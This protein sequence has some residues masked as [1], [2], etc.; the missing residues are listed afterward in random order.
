MG[1]DPHAHTDVSRGAALIAVDCVFHRIDL[2]LRNFVCISACTPLQL[3][4]TRSC[5]GALGGPV[6]HGV[7]VGSIDMAALLADCYNG[8]MHASEGAVPVGCTPPTV[9][10][11]VFS[12]GIATQ[13][14][15]QIV[16]IGVLSST[17]QGRLDLCQ[18]TRR[19]LINEIACYDGIQL[20]ARDAC[21][22]DPRFAATLESQIHVRRGAILISFGSQ[23]LGAIVLSERLYLLVPHANHQ[24][25][26]TIQGCYRRLVAQ[27]TRG[28][29][30]TRNA[31]GCAPTSLDPGRQSGDYPCTSAASPAA[32]AATVLESIAVEAGTVDPS[33]ARPPCSAYST[34]AP[35][36]FALIAIEALLMGA[37][38]DL[39]R[40]T[41]DLAA[42]VRTELEELTA[43]GGIQLTVG[44]E[45]LGIIREL[46]LRVDTLQDQ[47]RSLDA[48][49]SQTLEDEAA[50]RGIRLTVVGARDGVGSV[51]SADI[52]ATAN[53]PGME[54]LSA[55]SSS[56][57]APF[58]VPPG[59]APPRAP[60]QMA[61]V[62]IDAAEQL[63]ETYLGHVRTAS[64][65]LERAAFNIAGQE[66]TALLM[67]DQVRNRL[68]K[69]DVAA[70]SVSA[71]AGL[72]ACIASVFGMNTPA[73]ILANVPADPSAP[74]K[75][76]DTWLFLT[77]T[78]CIAIMIAGF[79][80][81]VLTFLYAPRCRPT[82]P[83]ANSLT[84]QRQ[85]RLHKRSSVGD[86]APEAHEKPR[87]S[88]FRS[89]PWPSFS[90]LP[91][92]GEP[93]NH[94]RCLRRATDIQSAS[95]RQLLS[96]EWPIGGGS[97][98]A[99]YGSAR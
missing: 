37:C 86:A 90:L 50:I 31:R 65:S 95:S 76:Y 41:S 16:H 11:P 36:P 79:I 12:V 64:A 30:A 68:L 94:P 63:L 13:D 22:V 75:R 73:P 57:R 43:H 92:P 97:A 72:G 40:H 19:Q 91:S 89:T 7:P 52:P 98:N 17:D 21:K 96:E 55:A 10:D 83:V 85:R 54:P 2:C 84:T 61:P 45:W 35:F 6:L 80:V 53:V 44:T 3:T 5:A 23:R 26:L 93:S 34:P 25:L 69:V 70:S 99:R 14:S 62:A 67:L 1:V 51:A 60:R 39:H 49:L 59:N 20:T 9:E 88:S 32:G 18:M 38:T 24:L 33:A 82:V 28:S 29:S 77:V 71:A 48:A 66:K 15:T 47:A 87:S 58:G 74:G 46:R 4:A 56:G 42:H 81:A 78:S 8:G 27:N